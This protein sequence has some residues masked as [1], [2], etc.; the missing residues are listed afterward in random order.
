MGRRLE[1]ANP[2]GIEIVAKELADGS[3]AVGLFNRAESAQVAALRFSDLGRHGQ[4]TVRD[5]WRQADV[6]QVDSIFQAEIPAHGV[7]L[8]K[9]RRDPE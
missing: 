6:G 9:L 1:T 8:I 4:H 7:I 3:M 5:L 2:D